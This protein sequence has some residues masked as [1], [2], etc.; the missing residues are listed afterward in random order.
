MHVHVHVHRSRPALRAPRARRQS[1]GSPATLR[2]TLTDMLSARKGT[3][4]EKVDLEKVK[5]GNRAGEEREK[6]ELEKEKE[7]NRAAER[8]RELTIEETKAKAQ[9]KQAKMTTKLLLG[10]AA[11]AGL[12]GDDDDDDD[13]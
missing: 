5:E 4:K 7:K 11:K 3:A 6:A 9:A 2:E 10:L 8:A 13:D 12:V 1:P